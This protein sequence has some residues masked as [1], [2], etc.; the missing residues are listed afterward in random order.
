MV[1]TITSIGLI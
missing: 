1:Y